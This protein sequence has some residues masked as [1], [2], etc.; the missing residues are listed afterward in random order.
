MSLATHMHVFIDRQQMALAGGAKHAFAN[1]S[2]TS[3]MLNVA[4]RAS[5]DSG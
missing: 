3:E 4:A 2:K 1:I 5:G